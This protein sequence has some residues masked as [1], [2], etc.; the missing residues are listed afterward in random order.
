MPR[1]NRFPPL[2]LRDRELRQLLPFSKSHLCELRRR[3][4]F[5]DG[6]PLFEGSRVK[7]WTWPAVSAW[8]E[9]RLGASTARAAIRD[10]LRNFNWDEPDLPLS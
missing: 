10:Y 6:E 8:L 9:Q 4:Q 2:V 7:V 5:P 1:R 3:G